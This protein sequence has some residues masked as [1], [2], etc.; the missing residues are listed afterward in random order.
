MNPALKKLRRLF[1]RSLGLDS[2]AART[3]RQ[4][5]DSKMLLAKVLGSQQAK[6]YRNLRDAEFK[7]FSQFGDD[8]IIQ[9]L[10]GRLQI[11]PR[12]FI[13]FGVEDYTESNT[14]FLLMANNWKGL[15]IDGSA[16]H[17][18]FIKADDIYWKHD[19]TAVCSFITAE[20]INDIFTK[21]GFEGEIG[22]LSIDI[23]GND[24]HV[25]EAIHAVRPA[26][27]IVE[28]NSVFGPADAIT[29]P[30]DPAFRRLHAHYSGLYFGASLTALCFLAEKKGFA[31]V[32][33]NNAGNNA[34]FVRRDKLDGLEALTASAGYV[35]SS[36]RESRD[37]D[38]QLTFVSGAARLDLIRDMPVHDVEK[39]VVRKIRE[40][41][42]SGRS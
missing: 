33:C 20:N 28:Y 32:G 26:L 42:S 27:V 31:F 25:W 21:H 6:S 4:L 1:R 35:Q 5:D 23:D 19:L 16:E 3:R 18:G 10:L 12:T 7:V 8:G 13:E 15:V 29:I 24:Y 30:Y 11:E 34:Y 38:G 22:L 36:I 14:R 39:G 2:D 40:F 41:N 37:P 17:I 9:Y